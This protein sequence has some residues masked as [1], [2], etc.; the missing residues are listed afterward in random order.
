MQKQLAKL[1]GQLEDTKI[2]QKGTGSVELQRQ[3]DLARARLAAY[4]AKPV[5][6][7]A[8]ELQLFQP[9]VQQT[10]AATNTAVRVSRPLPAGAAPLIAEAH[11]PS[12]QSTGSSGS[13]V[14]PK[15]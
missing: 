8:E 5:P 14:R 11:A 10:A 2:R 9:T 15:P 7:S 13:Q 6:Y 4:E 12:G 1:H 3:L